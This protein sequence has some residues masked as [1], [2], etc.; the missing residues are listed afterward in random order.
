R[1]RAVHDAPTARAVPHVAIL[2]NRGRPARGELRAGRRPLGLRPR[3]AGRTR[4]GARPPAWSRVYPGSVAPVVLGEDLVEGAAGVPED[5]ASLVG[6]AGGRHLHG[7][8]AD[9]E[10]QAAEVHEALVDAAGGRGERVAELLAV[11]VDVGA[12]LVG[13]LV[14]TL[15]LELD[16]A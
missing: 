1:A 7:R 16:G 6:V 14:G 8:G 9:L 11:L 15:A 4:P 13:E 3:V 12:A 10:E 2:C 5:L